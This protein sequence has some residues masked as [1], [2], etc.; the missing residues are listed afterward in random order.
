MLIVPH[1]QNERERHEDNLWVKSECYRFYVQQR[2]LCCN[3]LQIMDLW[4]IA[5]CCAKCAL[6]DPF[7]GNEIPDIVPESWE[8]D[9]LL[10]VGQSV[11]QQTKHTLRENPDFCFFCKM[12]LCELRPW[13]N[14]EIY[15]V[16]Y[17]L[18]EHYGIPLETPQR[19]KPSQRL[20]EQIIK[21][22]DNKCFGCNSGENYLHIDHILP[23]TAGGDAAFR[24]LQPL[25]ESCGNRKGNNLPEEIKVSSTI[26]F[27]PYPSDGYEGLFW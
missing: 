4:L 6:S 20:R 24:N 17:H 2:R 25:C 1:I 5:P 15:V 3:F 21:L 9:L 18:E 8:L 27:G 23:K 11:L 22:Y 26:Y 12:C 13:M 10:N 19:K 7:A 14:S 16:S